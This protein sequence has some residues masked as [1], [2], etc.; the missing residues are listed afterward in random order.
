MPNSN[1]MLNLGHLGAVDESC[2][3]DKSWIEYSQLEINCNN[4][5]NLVDVG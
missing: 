1:G 3:R 2:T 4:L 5:V